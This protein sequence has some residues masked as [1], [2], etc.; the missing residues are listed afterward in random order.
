VA[1]YWGEGLAIDSLAAIAFYF[2][3]T[4]EGERVHFPG[5]WKACARACAADNPYIKNPYI[6]FFRIFE[7]NN[8][9]SSSFLTPA[10]YN[11]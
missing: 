8:A 11:F 1:G 2:L 6:F 9:N 4:N 7:S 3:V 10:L 5:T